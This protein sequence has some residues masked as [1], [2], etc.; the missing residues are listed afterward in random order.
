MGSHTQ[1]L[2]TRQDIVVQSLQSRRV[3]SAC[4]ALRGGECKGVLLMA[5]VPT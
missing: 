5:V 3:I 2:C 1:S 4:D